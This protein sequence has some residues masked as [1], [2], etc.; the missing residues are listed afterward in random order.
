MT[1]CLLCERP[2]Q[3]PEAPLC[4]EH[5]AQIDAALDELAQLAQEMGLY[6]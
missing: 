6:E 3:A 1:Q 5:E 4:E 2:A